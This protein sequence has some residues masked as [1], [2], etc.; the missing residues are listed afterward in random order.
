[1]TTP[2]CRIVALP[3]TACRRPIE[4]RFD[5]TSDSARRLWLCGPDRLDNLHDETDIYP[6]DRD[7]S[8]NRVD[9]ALQRAG[10][11][12]GVL[13]V[14]PAGLMRGNVGLG[15]LPERHRL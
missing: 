3:V 2:P 13:R 12:L 11:L 9:V 10:P 14:L 7:V 6:P 4:H 1:M 8:N 15:S 5:A